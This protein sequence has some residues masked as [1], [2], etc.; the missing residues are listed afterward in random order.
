MSKLFTSCN[1]C[2]DL[3]TFFLK[4]TN[5]LYTCTF[6][7]Y[8]I[9]VTTVTS[10]LCFFRAGHAWKFSQQRD[11][12]LSPKAVAFCVSHSLWVVDVANKFCRSLVT[13][14]HNVRWM[15]SESGIF[16]TAKFKCEDYE[17]STVGFS[18]GKFMVN[19]SQCQLRVFRIQHYQMK[20]GIVDARQ[21]P[22]A[23]NKSSKGNYVKCANVQR[24]IFSR[25]PTTLALTSGDPEN[26][27]SRIFPN[28]SA[29]LTW[30]CTRTTQLTSWPSL[31][32]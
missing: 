15:D 14:I 2:I 11:N 1:L 30:V 23:C 32:P 7:I 13:T 17:E 12:V 22:R 18:H 4:L 9:S 25:L 26:F 6:L 3:L 21:I 8:F 24:N 20:Y 29:L 16:R 19:A 28:N 5:L 27:S 10:L 31:R